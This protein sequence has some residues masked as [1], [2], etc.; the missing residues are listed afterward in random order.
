MRAE[1][2]DEFQKRYGFRSDALPSLEYFDEPTLAAL[3]AELNIA[4]ERASSL[5][6]MEVVVASLEGALAGP[7][8]AIALLDSGGSVCLNHDHHPASARHQAKEPPLPAGGIGHCGGSRRK[9]R[10]RHRGRQC[11]SAAGSHAGPHH[12]RNGRGDAGR[13]RDARSAN[14]GRRP[15]VPRFPPQ[16]SAGAR[17]SGAAIFHRSTRMP[18]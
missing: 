14:G 2:H 8:S 5:V 15:A 17:W 11:R 1:R 13:F 12:V 9:R 18:R 6:R 4:V 10:V 7:P 3:A 16:V